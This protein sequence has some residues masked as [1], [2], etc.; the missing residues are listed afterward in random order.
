MTY[1]KFDI[2]MAKM[3]QQS[4]L[5]KDKRLPKLG[6]Y[7]INIKESSNLYVVYENSQKV[8]VSLHGVQKER[9]NKNT[10]RT[11]AGEWFLNQENNKL[12]SR[13]CDYHKRL[14]QESRQVIING[15]SL[16]TLIIA[17]CEVKNRG[18]FFTGN[19]YAPFNRSPNDEVSNFLSGTSRY[20]KIFYEN[21]PVSQFVLLNKI[22]SNIIQLHPWNN[23]LKFINPHSISNFTQDVNMDIRTKHPPQKHELDQEQEQKEPEQPLKETTLSIISYNTKL[24]PSIILNQQNSFRAKHIANKLVQL[25]PDVIGLQELFGGE[26]M[27]IIKKILGKAGYSNSKSFGMN[28]TSGKLI[29]SG[30]MI[31][32]RYPIINQNKTVFKKGSKEDEMAG[33]GSMSIIIEKNGIK[34]NLINSHYQSGRQQEHFDIKGT[35]M[36]QTNKLVK[37][38]PTILFGDFNVDTNKFK[39]FFD[40]QNEKHGWVNLGPNSPTTNDGFKDGISNNILDHMLY[41]VNKDYDISGSVNVLTDF[42]MNSSYWIEKKGESEF[43]QE[44]KD[45]GKKIKGL[46]KKKKQRRRIKHRGKFKTHNLSDHYPISGIISIKKL[47]DNSIINNIQ[48]ANFKTNQEKS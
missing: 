23:P 47:K 46:F 44:A 4:Y 18:S 13:F 35:Q 1:T 43:I 15:H 19:L 37:E 8:I 11:I 12:V 45:V 9:F 22:K 17:E 29:G 36:I 6:D 42:R 2:L 40:N 30:V 41:S 21:D 34:I 26:E 16:G 39:T 38:E 7:N 10:I 48:N 32:S 31:F 20:K 28:I 14:K 33:K 3:V 24:F 27:D 25:S 5:P